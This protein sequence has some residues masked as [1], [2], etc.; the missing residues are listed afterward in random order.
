V[1]P[2]ADKQTA[3][4]ADALAPLDDFMQ[5]CALNFTDHRSMLESLSK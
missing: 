2:V 5:R 3:P 1:F 4:G